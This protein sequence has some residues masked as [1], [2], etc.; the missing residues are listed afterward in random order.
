MEFYWYDYETFGLLPKVS[1]IAQFAGVRTDEN[2]AIIS[3]DMFY[4]KPTNDVL[5]MP[6]ACAVTKL[7]PQKCE[8][9]GVIEHEFIKQINVL[10]SK[11]NTCV[12]GYNSIRFDDEFTRYTL[13]R[14]FLDPYAW[15]YKNNNSRWDILDVVRLCYAFKKNQSLNWVFDDKGHP[16]FKLD[17]L[18][19]TNNIEHS[20]AHD[21]SADVLAT[22]AIAKIIK[23]TQPKL[24]DYA[25]KL[26]HKATVISKIKLFTPM[27]HVSGMYPA[28]KSCTRLVVALTYGKDHDRVFVFNLDQDPSVLL[29]LTI[30]E[31][32]T[33]LF[34][35]QSKLATGMEHLQIKQLIFNKS[36]IFI[37]L[38]SLNNISTDIVDQLQLDVDRANIY[39]NFINANKEAIADKVRELFKEEYPP[40][41]D[42][43]QALYDGFIS[44][45]DR[46]I[47]ERIQNMHL[48]ELKFFNPKFENAKLS[49]LLINFKARNYPQI[50]SQIEKKNWLKI[51]KNRL[52]G[53]DGYI[54]ID[55]YHQSIK[56]MQDTYPEYKKLW[57]QLINYAKL[58]L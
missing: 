5:P 29:N 9:E 2:L 6:E 37:M 33:S 8:Q 4:C 54:S 35:E 11:P 55:D 32:K 53:N 10:F 16:I 13:Y 34:V 44:N 23:T 26:R 3:K 46:K 39:F 48:N 22:I 52:N 40:T 38:K 51:L 45:A 25:F 41:Q 47:C 42:V 36:P 12:V 14:N 30:E 19:P 56:K 58:F 7:T 49:K 50:L 21:A 18:A 31:L 57:Q 43:D 20:K 24:F 15:H 27:L 17:K 1:R 28:S